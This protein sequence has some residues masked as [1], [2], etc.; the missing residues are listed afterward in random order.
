MTILC[1]HPGRY[2]DL[3]WA[4]PTLRALAAQSGQPVDLLLSA[5]YGTK[6]FG[7]LLSAQ[8]YLGQVLVAN[9]W[10]I[11]ETAPITPREPPSLPTGYDQ[12]LHLGYDGWPRLSLPY[13][14]ARIAGLTSAAIDLAT[15]WIAPTPPATRYV[16]GASVLVGF[17]D[18][19]FEV[20]A[21]LMALLRRQWGWVGRPRFINISHGRRWNNEMR[22]ESVSWLRAASWLGVSRLFVGC[23]SALHVLAC[24]VGRP[25]VCVEPALARHHDVFYPYG[26]LGPQVT[27][28]TGN[29][30]QPT[31][32]SR[33]L[34]DAIQQAVTHDPPD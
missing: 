8:P 1:T 18:E 34:V 7:A 2:G 3:L 15:P 6:G 33:H 17:T 4:L 20:K 13:E 5:K 23:C 26:K 25:V 12:V 30:G 9:N 24:G 27:L 28:V 22:V 19:Y 10:A 14:T 32:D 11:E 31:V 16:L 21:G 29:D